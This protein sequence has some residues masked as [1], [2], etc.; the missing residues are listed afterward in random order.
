MGLKIAPNAEKTHK[1]KT[2]GTIR[3]WI[4]ARPDYNPTQHQVM[5]NDEKYDE[6][7][8]DLPLGPLDRIK[9]IAKS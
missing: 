2:R 8:L 3:E 7:H 4:S 1:R 5:V 6:A 9:I